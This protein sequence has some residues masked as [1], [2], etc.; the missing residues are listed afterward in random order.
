MILFFLRYRP[1]T[2]KMLPWSVVP[3]IYQ[4]WHTVTSPLLT[5][6][7]IFSHKKSKEYIKSIQTNRVF[8]A[9]TGYSR[10]PLAIIMRK[11]SKRDF[12][13][14]WLTILIKKSRWNAQKRF[15]E[16]NL[17]KHMRFLDQG[18]M[19]LVLKTVNFLIFLYWFSMFYLFS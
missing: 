8:G 5:V 17:I 4:P 15:I 6:T 11:L 1:V 16:K 7:W 3:Y 19:G 13:L 10:D 2:V 12:I 9:F 18:P 14:L